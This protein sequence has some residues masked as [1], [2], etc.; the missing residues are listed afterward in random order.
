MRYIITDRALAFCPGHVNWRGHPRAL[1]MATS[2]IALLLSFILSVPRA[3]GKRKMT[4]IHLEKSE[5]ESTGTLVPV[6]GKWFL[7]SGKGRDKMTWIYLGLTGAKIKGQKS[8]AM[9]PLLPTKTQ[10]KFLSKIKAIATKLSAKQLEMS[11]FVCTMS[12]LK[13]EIPTYSHL[14]LSV[15]K[16][17][18]IFL[19]LLLSVSLGG[20]CSLL[21]WGWMLEKQLLFISICSDTGYACLFEGFQ[22][23]YWECISS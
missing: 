6:R 22:S 9:K 10:W 8:G 13:A 21:L 12:H 11:G 7:K 5:C 17:L 16:I 23:L 2:S 4:E 18:F 14:I 19:S 1:L 15:S 3:L 20:L